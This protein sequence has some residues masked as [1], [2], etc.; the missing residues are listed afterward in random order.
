ME[1]IDFGCVTIDDYDEIYEYADALYRIKGDYMAGCTGWFFPGEFAQELEGSYSDLTLEH[2]VN[3][4]FNE[5]LYEF[6]REY[7]H[8]EPSKVISGYLADDIGG[9]YMVHGIGYNWVSD[10]L[11]GGRTATGTAREFSDWL[12]NKGYYCSSI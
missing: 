10:D 11:C 9:F 6:L 5:L 12:E 3:D 4:Q 1:E 7:K 2:F 8:V